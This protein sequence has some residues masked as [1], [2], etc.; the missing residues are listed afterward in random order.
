MKYLTFSIF[1]INGTVCA[2]QVATALE[3]LKSSRR[4]EVTLQSGTLNVREDAAHVEVARIE[5]AISALGFWGKL[6]HT[7]PDDQ[8][9][10]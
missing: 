1:G 10:L 3:K 9:F 7:G 5:A 2:K 4:V 8:V 6:Q